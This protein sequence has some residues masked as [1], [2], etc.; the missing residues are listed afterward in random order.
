MNETIQI[1]TINRL[2][3]DRETPQGYYLVSND[4][5]SVLLPNR[6]ITD[7]MKLDKIIDVFIYSDSEDRLVATTETPPLLLGEVGFFE[8]VDS[9]PHG[10]YLDWGLSKDLLVPKSLQKNPF[11]VGQKR[12][13]RLLKDFNSDRLIGS[14]KVFKDILPAPKNLAVN[15]PID[16]IVVAKTPLGYKI[17]ADSKYEGIIYENEI[18]TKIRVPQKITAFVKKVRDDGKLDIS[19][20]QIGKNRFGSIA[21]NIYKKI[22]DCGGKMPYNYKS[23][24]EAIKKEFGVSKKNFKAALTDLVD[25]NKIEIKESGIYIINNNQTL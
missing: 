8:V 4:N 10:A 18:F 20:Q 6:Y 7:E 1:G 13:I 19:L 23:D 16:I 14:E 5:D 9:T 15:T 17:I 24:A 11:R 2:R 25:S 21:D 12:I 22:T 3:I